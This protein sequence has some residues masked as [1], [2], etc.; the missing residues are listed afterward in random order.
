MVQVLSYGVEEDFEME[1]LLASMIKAGASQEVAKKVAKAIKIWDG[2]TTDD[3][4]EQ[5]MEKLSE[6]DPEAAK[7]YDE[8]KKKK[9]A[10]LKSRL[11]SAYTV[12][13]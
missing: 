13:A 10:K 4:R 8:Y 5:V 1:K 2:M 7:R 3:I 11:D 9:E 6:L 12:S